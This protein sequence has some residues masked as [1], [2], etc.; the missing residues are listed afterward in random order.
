MSVGNAP[1]CS[2]SLSLLRLAAQHIKEFESIM[3]VLPAEAAAHVAAARAHMAAVDAEIRS[4]RDSALA[5][6]PA[7]S[8]PLIVAARVPFTVLRG[9][10]A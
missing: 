1:R 2:A 7:A 4:M 3:G 8:I 10:R 5:E 6:L 9:G